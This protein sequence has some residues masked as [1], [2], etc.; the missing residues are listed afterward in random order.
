M[1]RLAGAQPRV[2]VFMAIP[3]DSDSH[4]FSSGELHPEFTFV[5]S[6]IFNDH[7][8]GVDN[9]NPIIVFIIKIKITE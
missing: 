1:L 3:P 4:V 6:V 2:I 9:F 8:P 7:V 5:V